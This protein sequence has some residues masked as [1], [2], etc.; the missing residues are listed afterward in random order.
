MLVLL[1][2]LPRG[3]HLAHT[4]SRGHMPRAPQP[5]TEVAELHFIDGRAEAQRTGTCP[6]PRLPG[7]EG[8][9]MGARMIR[10][11]RLRCKLLATFSPVHSTVT[12]VTRHNTMPRLHSTVN[13]MA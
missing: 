7:G 11:S 2:F 10:F 8:Y 4:V 6:Q 9:L 1:C 12:D 5:V 13:T 3:E